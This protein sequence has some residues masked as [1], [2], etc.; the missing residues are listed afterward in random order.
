MGR[1]PNWPP[2]LVRKPGTTEAR[3]Y[4]AGRWWT[5]GTWDVAAGAPTP[6]AKARHAVLLARWLA[7]PG[8]AVRP[9][10]ELLVGGLIAD[11][12][13]SADGAKTP[14]ARQMARLA[15]EALGDLLGHPAAAFGPAELLGWQAALGTRYAVTTVAALRRPVLQAF[16]WGEDTDRL[17]AGHAAR[18]R[19]C[20]ARR[21]TPGRPLRPRPPAVE[22]HV[23]AALRVLDRRAPGVAGLVRVHALVGG[24]VEELLDLEAPAV[25]RAGVLATPRGATLNLTKEKVWGAV[26]ER[27]KM[28]QVQDRALVFGPKAQALLGPLLRGNAGRVFDLHAGRPDNRRRGGD[29]LKARV[30]A[31]WRWVNAAC[32]KAKVPAWTPR[33]LRQMVADRVE[34]RFGAEHAAAYLGHGKKG[35]TQRYYLTVSLTKAAEAARAVG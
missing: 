29:S 1:K 18:L 15:S 25:R 22:A 7:D 31:Y 11:W 9:K 34:R 23:R 8:S 6:E 20:V 13:A 4:H 28:R 5:C 12:L 14:H 30:H 19:D 35:T 2:K 21:P 32:K 3:T 24:R 16:G 10:G 17:P 27:H 33:Q 26:V